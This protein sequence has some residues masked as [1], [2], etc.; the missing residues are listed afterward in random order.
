M[1]KDNTIWRCDLRSQYK[2]YRREIDTAIK[3]VLNSGRYILSDEVSGFEKEFADY[4]G[5]KYVIGVGNATDG[6]IL[7]LKAF[8]I[9]AGDE[10]ITT[11]FTAIPTVSAI[12]ATGAKP[13]FADI[14]EKTFLIDIDKISCLITPKTKAI[15]PVHIFGNVVDIEKLR[16]IIPSDIPII[17]D[18][19]QSHGSK[20][21]GIHTGTVGD[22]GVFSFYPTKNLGGYGDGG[23]VVTNNSKIA[24]KVR[25]MRMYGMTDKD[26]I[27]INGINSRLDE[28]Q[29]AILRVKLKYL[30]EMN[31]RRRE[32]A[33]RYKNE[34][35]ND[36][37]SFQYVPNGVLCNYHVF[38]V[39]VNGSRDAMVDY[40]EKRHIQ[41]NIYY[42]VP[43]HLQEANKCL[44]Y[45]KGDFPI[46][47]QLC[48]QVIALPM[49]PELS[50]QKLSEVIKAVN[51]FTREKRR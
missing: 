1:K 44:G 7:S 48:N 38:A 50:K 29:A 20:M 47:E 10:I 6:L 37:L 46:T 2:R 27:I 36:Y 5:C 16:G 34:L 40:L 41:T 51:S 4:I 14:D 24:E 43:L 19:A 25:L 21:N 9:G 32:I 15:L 42:Y 31:R 17:E 45:Q 13:V 18:S 33:E 8:G 28:L 49:Y 22:I 12:I 26:H 35:D 30:D 11:P 39:R 3:R 23:T